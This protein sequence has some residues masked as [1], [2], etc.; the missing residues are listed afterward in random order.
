MIKRALEKALKGAA[1]KYPVVTLTG[2]RQSGKTTLA[3]AAFPRHEYVSLEDPDRREFAL[4]DPRGFLGQFKGKVILDEVQRA[5]ELFSYIQTSVDEDNRSGRF[6]LTGSHNFLL[7]RRIS[8]S[9]AGRSAI[10]HL[11]PLSLSELEA[12]QPL[13]LSVIGTALPKKGKAPDSGIMEIMFRGFYPRIHDKKLGPQEWLSNYYQTYI[14]RDVREI[15]NV[16]DIETFARFVRLC[17]GRNGQLLN[18]SSLAN[19][20]GVTHT[21][22]RRWISILEASFQ[23]ILLRPHDRNFSKRMIKS[24][25]L[26]FL[27]TGML[28]YLLRI[29]SPGDLGLHASRG[30]IFEGFVLSELMKNRL[31][32]G[33]DTDLYFWRDFEGHEIDIILDRGPRAIPIEVKSGQTI[34]EDS[35]KN[36]HYWS[37]LAGADAGPGALVYAGAESYM[38]SGVTVYSW[39]CL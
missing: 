30:S 37:R 15:V 39:S 28:C 35:F 34:T 22:A 8:Q 11:L 36:L 4:G 3:K 31:N 13:A 7:M 12:R 27:D 18:L 25:K 1:G 21:T 6:V 10:L 24:P 23:V 2:P 26:Y 16:G 5:P 20:C 19:D 9:L 29:N 33:E 32:R 38:R 17:A 14:E